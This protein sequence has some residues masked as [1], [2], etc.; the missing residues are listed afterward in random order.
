[1][2][3]PH[4][5]EEIVDIAVGVGGQPAFALRERADEDVVAVVEDSGGRRRLTARVRDA[6]PV[7][8]DADRSRRLRSLSSSRLLIDSTHTLT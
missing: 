6:Q 2:M 3:M 4:F 5:F 7:H 1:M 8:V